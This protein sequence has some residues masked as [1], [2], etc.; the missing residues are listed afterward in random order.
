MR[1]QYDSLG[2]LVFT[3][4][5][6]KIQRINIDMEELFAAFGI[7]WKLLLVQ[8]LNFGLL[9][10]VLTYFLYKPVFSMIRARREKIEEGVRNAEEAARKLA[11]SDIK[12]KEVVTKASREA[13][14]MLAAA[15]TSA[16][17]KKVAMMRDAEARAEAVMK[18]AEARAA[19]AERQMRAKSEREIAKT[20]M[21]AAEKI[22]RGNH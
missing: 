20:A 5:A 7:N 19:E 3:S 1:R 14:G 10:V 21:L 2:R 12:G 6:S 13:E 15:R 17:E 11:E 8:A 22:M 18:D 9:L 4:V 16:E